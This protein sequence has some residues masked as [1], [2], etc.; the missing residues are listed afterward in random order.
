MET[1]DWGS[2]GSN[3][4]LVH[5]YSPF[6]KHLVQSTFATDILTPESGKNVLIFKDKIYFKREECDG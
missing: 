3:P 5:D 1:R 4:I 6:L 2:M